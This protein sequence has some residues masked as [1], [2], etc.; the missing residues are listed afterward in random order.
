MVWIV[1]GGTNCGKA[2][3]IGKK[4]NLITVKF[5]DGKVLEVDKRFVE[6]I[7]EEDND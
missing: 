3:I 2:K 5:E 4:G 1:D 6:L 7:P